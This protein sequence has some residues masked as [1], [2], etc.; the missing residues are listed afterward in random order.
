MNKK[1]RR[2]VLSGMICLSIISSAS[3]NI[4]ANDLNASKEIQSSKVF[5]ENYEISKE[6]MDSYRQAYKEMYGT[7]DG[8]DE[9]EIRDNSKQLIEMSQASNSTIY[10]RQM[11]AKYFEKIKWITRDGV[12]SLS[13]YP[14]YEFSGKTYGYSYLAAMAE[15]SWGII[16]RNYSSS[17]NWKNTLSLKQQYRCHVHY[18]RNAKTPWNIEPHR[19][20]TNF[21]KVVSAG[22][23][24]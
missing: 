1:G 20:E 24:P 18:A 14:T 6:K 8:F 19:T 11:I 13:I 2:L 21:D 12:V 9:D 23:N 4:F 3:L 7:E 15:E 22:C 17:S 10:G 16:V 5:V